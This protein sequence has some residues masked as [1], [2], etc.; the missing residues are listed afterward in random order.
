MKF[1]LHEPRLQYNRF[2]FP[3][4]RFSRET[5]SANTRGAERTRASH[6][7]GLALDLSLEDRAFPRDQRQKKVCFAVYY[8][9]NC[10]LTGGKS[11]CGLFLNKWPL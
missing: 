7:V 4:T 6:L 1:C 2:S 8:E 9:P 3:L 10:K 5:K 11:S